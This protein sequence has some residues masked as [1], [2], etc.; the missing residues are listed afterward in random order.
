MKS[1]LLPIGVLLLAAIFAVDCH[2]QIGAGQSAA[3]ANRH[4]NQIT[5]HWQ[6]G[7]VI[8]SGSVPATSVNIAIPVPTDWPEQRVSIV[9]ENISSVVRNVK[10][11]TLEDGVRRLTATVPRI[12]ANATVKILLKFEVQVEETLAPEKTD[13]L[14]IPKKVPRDVKR[15]LN[16]SPLINH[17]KTELKRLTKE[18]TE[19]KENAWD[20]VK[21]FYDWIQTNIQYVDTDEVKGA[22]ITFKRKQ[23]NGEDK[24]NLFVALCRAYKVPA[25]IVWADGVQYAEFY[26]ADEEG[27]GIWYP[28]QPDG[29]PEFG[30]MT[31]PRVIQQKGDNIKVPEQ[32]QRRRLVPETVTGNTTG[33]EP[34]VI[35]VRRLLPK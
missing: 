14:V 5:Q 18:L 26:L 24:V 28:C 3:E 19:G 30:Q 2:A 15:H 6:V 20:Q 10:Y 8:R 23:G 33:A 22:V 1:I 11:Q 9:D 32:K 17:R 7:A 25:R 12:R 27:N 29:I 13:H 35:F 16:S 31:N 21:S 34:E 4:A